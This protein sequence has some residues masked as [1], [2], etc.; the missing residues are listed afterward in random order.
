MNYCFCRILGFLLFSVLH[1]WYNFTVITL[2][3]GFSYLCA[4]GFMFL[5][6]IGHIIFI[7]YIPRGFV[8]FPIGLI[9]FWY[10]INYFCLSS[11]NPTLFPYSSDHM[12][13][14]NKDFLPF[15]GPYSVLIFGEWSLYFRK[16]G[17]YFLLVIINI[18]LHC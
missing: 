7:R 6:F 13:V 4:S 17:P 18:L 12:W 15:L 8:G 5:L 2:L 14:L 16:V 10:F 1:G 11:Y 9:Y 3:Y